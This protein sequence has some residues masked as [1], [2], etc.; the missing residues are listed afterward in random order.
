MMQHIQACTA[1]FDI[2]QEGI[3]VGLP[4]PAPTLLVEPRLQVAGYTE[5]HVGAGEGGPDPFQGIQRVAADR[6]FGVCDEVGERAESRRA[7]SLARP[8]CRRAP[9][10]LLPGRTLRALRR[11]TPG[12]PG[13][14][15][16][17]SCL[18]CAYTCPIRWSASPG[19]RRS[20]CFGPKNGSR[21]CTADRSLTGRRTSRST[22]GLAP[23]ARRD[24]SPCPHASAGARS[25][26]HP[27]CSSP[28]KQAG[29]SERSRPCAASAAWVVP[30][31]GATGFSSWWRGGLRSSARG[32]PQVLRRCLGHERKLF[33]RLVPTRAPQ[34]ERGDH[35]Q[36]PRGVPDSIASPRP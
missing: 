20:W 16:P 25:R 1:G 30:A 14:A 13:T 35:G 34:R 18:R 29:S 4:A 10:T 26:P 24:R 2:S 17:R 22:T 7:S 11:G 19:S 21:R 23:A 28:E 36:R 32:G 33:G 9:G 31:C 3:A 5:G 6:P 27:W 8:A 15:R 12:H